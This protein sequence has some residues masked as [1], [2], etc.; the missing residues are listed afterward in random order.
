M[1]TLWNLILKLWRDKRIRFLFVGVLNTLVGIGVTYLTY[2]LMGYKVFQKDDI[3]PLA[4]FVATLLGQV[5]G[6]IHSYLWNKFFTFRSKDRSP[7]EFFRFAVI[8]VV[9]YGVNFG[10]TLLFK[11]FIPYAWLYTV[12]VTLICTVVSYIGHNL[13]SFKKQGD[14]KA[15]EEEQA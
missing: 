6:G 8:C 5:I 4:N 3:T 11:L 10:L 2:F 14:S 9:Q 1:K 12:I 15:Q 7:A 13:F